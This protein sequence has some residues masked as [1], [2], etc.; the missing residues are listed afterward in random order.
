MREQHEAQQEGQ[1]EEEPQ[2]V[3]TQFVDNHGLV[4]SG[5]NNHITVTFVDGKMKVEQTPMAKAERAEMKRGFS[6]CILDSSREEYVMQKLHSL[7]DGK[8]SKQSIMVLMAA[9]R[10]GI[11]SKPNYPVAYEEFPEIGSRPN[12]VKYFNG[13]NVTDEEIN[14]IIN[15]F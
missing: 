8:K 14:A 7:I 1:K 5:G 11:I 4:V 12:Y 6:S 13:T 9:V 2:L 15:N 3:N 10:C